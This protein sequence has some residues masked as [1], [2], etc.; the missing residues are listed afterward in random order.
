[1]LLQEPQPT[2]FD[3]GFSCCGI[4]VRV[5]GGFW[6]VAGLLGWEASAALAGGDQR[7]TLVNLGIWIGAAFISIL[8]HELGHALAYRSSGQSS[9]IVL[10]HFGGLTIPMAWGRQAVRSPWRR[11]FVSAAGPG[12]Q[13]LF[14]V[15]IVLILRSGGFRVPFPVQSLGAWWGFFAGRPLPAFVLEVFVAHLLWINIFWAVFNL[16]PVPP[17]DGGQIVQELLAGLGARDAGRDAASLGLLAGGCVAWWAYSRGDLYL[18]VLFV[19]LAYG[20]FQAVAGPRW[21]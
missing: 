2:S 8:G 5:T 6:V 9:R 7:Q 3:I 13:L 4:P 17:L 19:M 15:V 21:R 18:T 10:Y 20:C 12:M 11:L 14:A 16:L 1:M